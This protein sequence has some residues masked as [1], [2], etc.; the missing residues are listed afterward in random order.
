MLFTLDFILNQTSRTHE[1]PIFPFC[2]TLSNVRTADDALREITVPDAHMS[3]LPEGA[4][5]SMAAGDF[6]EI[7]DDQAGQWDCVVTCFFIDTA[8]NIVD[9]LE[10]IAELL[11][12]GG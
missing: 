11:A 9:Y 5:M 8:H 4:N 2:H 3:E 10:K 1:H 6:T 7:F 12:P